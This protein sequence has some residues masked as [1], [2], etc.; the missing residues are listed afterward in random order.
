MPKIVA[1]KNNW[2]ELGY[3]LFSEKGIAGIVVESM[4]K[5]L[6]VNKSSFYWHFSTKK[7]FVD[8]IIDYWEAESTS[9]IVSAVVNENTSH[10][11]FEKLI[12]LSF[13]KDNEIDFFFYLKKY[14]R[15]NKELTSRI[16]DLDRQRIEF[17]ASILQE[18][19]YPPAE[20]KVKASLFYKYLIGYHEMIRYKEQR[21]NYT[22]EVAEELSHFIQF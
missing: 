5:K 7:A 4:A 21:R 14:A 6:E 11:R 15:S 10:N 18:L 17:T 9:K 3:K 22:A 8:A 12:E 20:A 2:I 13:L 1:T 19:G 16:E